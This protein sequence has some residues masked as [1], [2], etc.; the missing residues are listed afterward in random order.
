M[1][2]SYANPYG[3]L[4]GGFWGLFWRFLAV[5]GP[6]YC[7]FAIGSLQFCN[8]FP[9]FAKNSRPIIKNHRAFLPV[10]LSGL[11]II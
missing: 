11:I 8:D 6:V 4:F 1:C 7:N 9:N 10:K 3:G 2:N 5:S